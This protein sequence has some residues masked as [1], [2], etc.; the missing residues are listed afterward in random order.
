MC[1]PR[2]VEAHLHVMLDIS[3]VIARWSEPVQGIIASGSQAIAHLFEPAELCRLLGHEGERDPKASSGNPLVQRYRRPDSLKH[4]LRRLAE[5]GNA[6]S[7]VGCMLHNSA[8]HF[9]SC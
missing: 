1:R 6:Y 4:C 8:E 3:L 7:L 5:R 9:A 2:L